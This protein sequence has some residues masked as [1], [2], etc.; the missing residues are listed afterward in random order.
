MLILMVT[1]STQ[2]FPSFALNS[3][4]QTPSQSSGLHLPLTKGFGPLHKDVPSHVARPRLDRGAKGSGTKL[5]V[6]ASED[7]RSSRLARSVHPFG[8]LEYSQRP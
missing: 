6:G 5:G 4:V 7:D 8:V 1:E 2:K 3:L